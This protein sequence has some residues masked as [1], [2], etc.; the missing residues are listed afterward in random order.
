MGTADLHTHT[1]LTDGMMDVGALLEYVQHHTSLDVVAV[2]DHDDITAGLLARELARERGYRAQVVV[3]AEITTL[4]GHLLGLFL[5]QNVAPFQPLATT[6]K[7]LHRQGGLAIVPH[8]MSWLTF[9]L[10]QRAIQRV[11]AS[12]EP[13][14]H[15]DG[16]ETQNPTAAGKVTWKKVGRLNQEQYH[17][18]EVGGSDA[19]FLA[20]VGSGYTRFPGATTE[21]LRRAIQQSRTEAASVS[22]AL[23]R[24]GY[25]ELVKQQVKSLV[26][27]PTRTVSRPLWRF[28]RGV[29]P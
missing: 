17:L 19:H 12:Q 5:E 21:E 11:L 22:V 15:F 16:I 23:S 10:G 14:V 1:S 25:G 7:A 2:T 6:L 9:S 8:P 29:G 3:G 13:G 27:H 28:L 4:E 26:L 18:A 24:I 20:A